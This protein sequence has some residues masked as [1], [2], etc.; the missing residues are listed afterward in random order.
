[1]KL[2]SKRLVTRL[3]VVSV[4]AVVGG[5]V[6]AQARIALK[7]TSEAGQPEQLNVEPGTAKNIQNQ[8]VIGIPDRDQS[9]RDDAR[10]DPFAGRGVRPASHTEAETTP[11][12]DGPGT[13]AD[14]RAGSFP[15]VRPGPPSQ[16][17]LID[18]SAAPLDELQAPPRPVPADGLPA[19][20]RPTYMVDTQGAPLETAQG[21]GNQNELR[22]NF[23]RPG[24]ALPTEAER[25][26]PPSAYEQNAVDGLP[27]RPDTN[28]PITGPGGVPTQ[29]VDA[30]EPASRIP[31]STLGAPPVMGSRFSGAP[32]VPAAVGIADGSPTELQTAAGAPP[33]VAALPANADPRD[34][35]GG[36]GNPA[37]AQEGTGTPG[38]AVLEGP[39]APSIA[40]QKFA[41][42]EIQ[43]GKPAQFAVKIKNV[44]RVA[45][46]HVAIRDVVPKGTRLIDTTPAAAETAGS[47]IIWELGTLDPNEE[48]T[49]SMQVMPLEE[50]EVGSVAQVTFAAQASVRTRATRPELVLEHSAPR[51]I[52]AGGQ[53]TFSIKI[54]NP[55]TGAATGV[56]IEE[57]VPEGLSHPAGRELEFEVGT[58]NPGQ[59]R[60]LELTLNADAAGTIE[61]VLVCRADANL[62]AEHRVSLEVTAPQLELALK[63]PS[64]RYLE[65]PAT[66]EIMIAN[67][68]TASATDVEMVAHLPQGMEFRETNNAG[69]YDA[70][71]HVVMWSVAELP[72]GG[73]G[74]VKLTVMPTDAGEKTI[75]VEGRAEAGLVDQY[76]HVVSVEGLASVF[77]ELA[78][79][80]DPIEVGGETLYEIRVINEGSKTSEN[81]EVV[82][83]LPPE[84]KPLSGEGDT[85]AVVEGQ[86][87]RFAP[88]PRLSPKADATYK[89]RA[90]GLAPG[91]HRIRVQVLSGEMSEPIIREESTLVYSD[92]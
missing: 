56:I 64:R 29:A 50:G 90:Q 12:Q 92:Q 85:R 37:A 47:E 15:T 86:T 48:K 77:F 43:V 30:G 21:V 18:G 51:K 89:V 5:M 46:E 78:D 73:Q 55:G 68:G 28:G 53:V 27:P 81:V 26:R 23:P 45:A 7:K 59:T 19:P 62:V 71:R 40:I 83:I 49:V 20:G 8:D 75:R 34:A 39:Q 33:K 63:G 31:R 36:R 11:P 4:V 61:N 25:G 91:D 57:N 10:T 82:A 38:E 14:D 42:P 13:Y 70:N 52:L 32:R 80:A 1:M 3:A 17:R 74:S 41:P 66:F 88:L 72:A 6:I 54:S 2:P 16:A 84:M 22:P 79:S 65:R 24:S 35:R 76:E 44:G 87:I 9:A 67:P 60:E 69:V 58:L